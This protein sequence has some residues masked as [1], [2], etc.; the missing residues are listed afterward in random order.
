MRRYFIIEKTENFEK[1]QSM[2]YQLCIW[3]Y[4][5]SKV[6]HDSRR[7][8]SH[9]FTFSKD[10]D[11]HLLMLVKVHYYSLLGVLEN[12]RIY[13]VLGKLSRQAWF[14]HRLPAIQKQPLNNS[15]GD[16]HFPL[17]FNY[18]LLLFSGKIAIWLLPKP[19]PSE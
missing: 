16:G 19:S 5:R 17:F 10:P 3:E 18:Q 8:M 6:I 13:I 9:Y 11:Y 1:C 2:S 7:R 14:Q 12:F 4:I 15:L